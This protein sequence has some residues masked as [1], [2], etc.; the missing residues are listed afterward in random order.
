MAASSSTKDDRTSELL[1]QQNKL[2][3]QLVRVAERLDNHLLHEQ[4][5]EERMEKLIGLF[6]QRLIAVET[7]QAEQRGRSVYTHSRLDRFEAEQSAMGKTVA[8]WAGVT[9]MAGVLLMELAKVIASGFF[10]S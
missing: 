6:D 9:G 7:E 4:R 3:A 5:H 2:T 1:D 8:K 10:G